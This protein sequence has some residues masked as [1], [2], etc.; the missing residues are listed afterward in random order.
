MRG[1]R[2]G[3]SLA[4]KLFLASFFL[5]VGICFANLYLMYQFTQ[6]IA[7]FEMMLGRVRG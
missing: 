6:I 7:A 5:N 4:G 3:D 1:R 2:Q